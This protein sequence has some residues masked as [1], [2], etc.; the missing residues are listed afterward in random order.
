MDNKLKLI[1]LSGSHRKD[2]INKKLLD[3]VVQELPSDVTYE[4]VDYSNVPVFNQDHEEPLPSSVE[5][6]KEKVESA[7]II[8]IATPEY[9]GSIPGVLKN[10]ID[11]LSRPAGQSSLKGKVAGIVGAS[12]G[13]GGTLKSQLHLRE[14]LSH[15]D[16]EV[17]NQPR[18]ML[19]FVDE[20]I[21]D[22]RL[23]LN[24]QKRDVVQNLIKRLI[25]TS[26]RYKKDGVL[27]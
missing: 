19:S 16:V 26:N 2:S 27:V 14:S 7:D 13:R 6:F 15:M 4:Y 1:G 3:A 5:D 23:I 24:E 8:L 17:P 21:Q 12:P 20:K 22:G 25:D 10:G 18:L 11:W 9:N